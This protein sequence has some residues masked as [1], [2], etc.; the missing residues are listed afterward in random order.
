MAAIQG[1]HVVTSLEHRNV[2]VTKSA[3]AAL[4]GRRPGL[5]QLPD[6]VS[7]DKYNYNFELQRKRSNKASDPDVPEAL[8]VNAEQRQPIVEICLINAQ[9]DTIPI[10]FEVVL[11]LVKAERAFVQLGTGTRYYL[12]YRRKRKETSER[13]L[14]DIRIKS[15]W[16]NERES[17]ASN[18]KLAFENEDRRESHTLEYHIIN[19]TWDGERLNYGNR[20][21]ARFL[22]WTKYGSSPLMDIFLTEN[23]DKKSLIA[24][25]FLTCVD[26]TGE[27]H[28]A[29]LNFGSDSPIFLCLQNDLTP[30]RF[31]SD[32]LDKVLNLKYITPLLISLHQRSPVLSRGALKC[33][34][35][36]I[37][38]KFLRFSDKEMFCKALNQI[39]TAVCEAINIC[40]KPQILYPLAPSKSFD[41]EDRSESKTQKVSRLKVTC[42]QMIADQLLVILSQMY[43]KYHSVETIWG[44]LLSSTRIMDESTRNGF[45]RKFFEL[46]WNYLRR[47]MKVHRFAVWDIE[48]KQTS[49]NEFQASNKP[50]RVGLDY[51]AKLGKAACVKVL[52]KNANIILNMVDIYHPRVRDAVKAICEQLFPEQTLRAAWPFVCT[53][54]FLARFADVPTESTSRYDG[55]EKVIFKQI[56]CMLTLSLDLLKEVLSLLKN[57]SRIVDIKSLQLV[58]RLIYPRLIAR[59]FLNHMKRNRKWAKEGLDFT[60]T[61][62]RN[63][64]EMEFWQP[65]MLVL[66]DQ[67]ILPHLEEPAVLLRRRYQM[68]IWLCE[69][70]EQSPWLVVWLFHAGEI[71]QSLSLM[72]RILSAASRIALDGEEYVLNS[73]PSDTAIADTDMGVKEAKEISQKALA[74]IDYI[75]NGISVRLSKRKGRGLSEAEALKLRTNVTK[76]LKKN[77]ERG[78]AEEKAWIKLLANSEKGCYKY[79]QFLREEEMI[80]DE[81]EPVVEWLLKNQH[82]LPGEQLGNFLG[83]SRPKE[84]KPEEEAIRME[85]FRGIVLTQGKNFEESVKEVLLSGFQ[86]PKEF[87]K[88]SRVMQSLSQVLYERDPGKFDSVDGVWTLAMALI[89]LNTFLHNPSVKAGDRMELSKWLSMVKDLEDIHR[90]FSSS[91]FERMYKYI[92]DDEWI[93]PHTGKVQEE[94]KRGGS[95]EGG[96][97]PSTMNENEQVYQKMAAQRRTTTQNHLALS[98][99]NKKEIPELNPIE[100]LELMRALFT[101]VW[102]DV[103]GVVKEIMK[104]QDVR[105][106]KVCITIASRALIISLRLKEPALIESCKTLSI[107]FWEEVLHKKY[108]AKHKDF[109]TRDR[110]LAGLRQVRHMTGKKI[111]GMCKH[112]QKQQEMM[113]KQ[114]TTWK[115]QE[116]MKELQEGFGPGHRILNDDRVYIGDGEVMK[117]NRDGKKSKY[118]LFLFNDILLY[119]VP[120]KEVKQYKI[121]Q[122][123]PLSVCNLKE[124]DEVSFEIINP[125]KNVTFMRET[126]RMKKKYFKQ[127]DEQIRKAR[128]ESWKVIETAVE[129]DP[130]KKGRLFSNTAAFIGIF[131]ESIDKDFDLDRKVRDDYGVGRCNSGT[132]VDLQEEDHVKVFTS[133]DKAS[134]VYSLLPGKFKT[135]TVSHLEQDT[136]CFICLTPFTRSTIRH[137][138]RRYSCKKCNKHCCKNCYGKKSTCK[139]CLE[140]KHIIA[141]IAEA[142]KAD[143]NKRR[144]RKS[145]KLRPNVR[146]MTELEI[147]LKKSRIDEEQLR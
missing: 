83:G 82:V 9:K 73:R 115:D 69:L 90:G 27:G 79:L 34:R 125:I 58:L 12:C 101:Q 31:S 40:E 122:V 147:R 146:D 5:G 96:G 33:I 56:K 42:Q 124:V 134:T 65:E 103:E 30:Y 95:L 11:S 116:K 2:I 75:L 64:R 61:I 45:V 49:N 111:D 68:L 18:S 93:L 54:F 76:K 143:Y 44:F 59:N 119:A 50:H 37:L 46:S 128:V 57:N 102:H 141:N 8:D 19:K 108:G 67:M 106:C 91:D 87:Q 7:D 104:Y 133:K 22:L 29:D 84:E 35:D 26:V 41:K 85:F 51:P 135:K 3:E 36:L 113:S 97:R 21:N 1:C 130:K 132:V 13:P 140:I 120:Q 118:Q 60:T 17:A 15:L 32:D 6:F 99:E 38:L 145:R 136:Y 10:G 81:T 123:I 55:E 126:A 74:L 80:S 52:K 43:I 98:L 63:L 62:M 129:H 137:I 53:L 117:V 39:S 127:L 131:K 109:F 107:E 25:R 72:Q 110:I 121:H 4:K 100:V 78:E 88:I 47:S 94:M 89:T 86:L 92:R 28:I 142:G 139:I 48:E 105:T 114:F 66:M 24:N 144:M 77:K 20:T 14:T 112:A 70:F 23:R 138:Y 16:P 71:C